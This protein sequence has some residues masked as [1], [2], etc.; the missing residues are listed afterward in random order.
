MKNHRELG[1]HF[2]RI[3]LCIFI[4]FRHP[5]GGHVRGGLRTFVQ[6]HPSM[7]ICMLI[8]K[9]GNLGFIKWCA[10]IAATLTIVLFATGHWALDACSLFLPH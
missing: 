4:E 7:D 10:V 8:T 3:S 6:K 5:S 9:F 2:Y 1:N